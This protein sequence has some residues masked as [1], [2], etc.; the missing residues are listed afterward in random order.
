MTCVLVI[1]LN[2]QL[3]AQPDRARAREWRRMLVNCE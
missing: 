1:Q 2:L 3:N